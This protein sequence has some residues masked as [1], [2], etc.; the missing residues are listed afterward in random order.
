MLVDYLPIFILMVLATGLSVFILIISAVFG[1]K[2]ARPQKYIPY[3]SG[4]VP[5]GT[6]RVRFPVKFYLI[7]MLFII[8]DIEV[9][10]LYPWAVVFRALKLFGLIEMGIFIFILLIGYVYVWKKGALEWEK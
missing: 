1:P 5:I 8:F 10:F 7:A 6:A 4:M 3:E 2:R 9:V